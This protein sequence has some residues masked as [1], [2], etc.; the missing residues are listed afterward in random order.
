MGAVSGFVNATPPVL[1]EKKP[2]AKHTETRPLTV[3]EFVARMM[4]E[5]NDDRLVPDQA[6]FHRLE[7][8]API[9]LL[10]AKSEGPDW[11]QKWC[12]LVLNGPPEKLA[13]HCFVLIKES[14]QGPKVLYRSYRMN[15]SGRLESAHLLTGTND[16][17]GKPI[18]GS[19]VNTPLDP[20]SEAVQKEAAE[21]LKFWLSNQAGGSK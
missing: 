19:A 12:D 5:A 10:F 1:T 20:N 9:K 21:E 18:R 15:L 4:R 2:S 8:L 13:P 6:Q 14:R 16:E 3:K 11:S 7:P 17:R